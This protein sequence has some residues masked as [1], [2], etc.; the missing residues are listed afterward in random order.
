MASVYGSGALDS[1]VVDRADADPVGVDLEDA[2]DA[3]NKMQLMMGALPKG[4]FVDMASRLDAR[5][6][7]RKTADQTFSST[8]TPANV[9]DMLLPVPTAGV[10]YRFVFE[11]V[12]T[13]AAV[14]NGIRL[15]L[16]TPTVGGYLHAL[17]QIWGRLNPQ[18]A[19]A[20]PTD[21]MEWTSWITA[22]GGNVASDAVAT[23][24]TNYP[25]RIT[26][27]LSNP[28]ATGNIQLTAANE[29]STASGNIIRRGAY[30]EV[31][32]A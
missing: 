31:Y 14:A 16:A 6:T 22:A 13:S 15:G 8:V 24:N 1:F 12:Y 5:L 32:L 23:I 25:F 7:C 17:V 10:D 27:I 19:G 11:G 3:I 20:A 2:R 18:A 4:T 9:A 26:G 28:S 30:G 21:L 29:V